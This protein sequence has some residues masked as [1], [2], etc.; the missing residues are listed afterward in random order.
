[1]EM[2]VKQSCAVCNEL[3]ELTTTIHTDSPVL[4]LEAADLHR[5]V[6]QGCSFCR[7]VY[8]AITAFAGNRSIPENG[9]YV[10]LG[11]YP[12]SESVGTGEDSGRSLKLEAF[13]ADYDGLSLEIFCLQGKRTQIVVWIRGD[14]H[15]FTNTLAVHRTCAKCFPKFI[16]RAM[17]EV[18]R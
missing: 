1:M 8:C 6:R 4:V 13:F 9:V 2:K 10:Q 16:F 15:R 5:N 7:L 3:E 18:G 14:S 11:Q 12:V 17:P